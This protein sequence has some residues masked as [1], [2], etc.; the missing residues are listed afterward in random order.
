MEHQI[1]RLQSSFLLEERRPWQR[2][3]FAGRMGEYASFVLPPAI[4]AVSDGEHDLVI[5]HVSTIGGEV[6]LQV[7]V[8]TERSFDGAGHEA[9]AVGRGEGRKKILLAKQELQAQAIAHL[10]RERE[11]LIMSIPE[12]AVEA[13]IVCVGA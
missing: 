10:L 3:R 12:G 5:A 11:G 13:G 2:T 8:R 9:A 7:V 1:P 4:K 6:S